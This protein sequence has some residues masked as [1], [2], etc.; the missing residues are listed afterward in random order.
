VLGQISFSI[1]SI[2]DTNNFCFMISVRIQHS[3]PYTTTGLIRVIYC[4]IKIN[5]LYTKEPVRTVQ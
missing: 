2:S 4:K 3:D 1:S 5:L